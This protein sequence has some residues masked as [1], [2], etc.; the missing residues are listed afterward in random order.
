MKLNGE[1]GAM[2]RKWNNRKIE[3]QAKELQKAADNNNKMKPIWTYQK[4]LKKNTAPIKKYRNTLKM[5]RKH[6]TQR[7]RSHAGHNVYNNTSHKHNKKK[8]K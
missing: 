8:E 3:Q 6:M 5:E 2:N 1:I 4:N 7:K